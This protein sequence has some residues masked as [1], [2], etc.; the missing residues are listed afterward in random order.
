MKKFLTLLV[1]TAMLFAMATTAFAA[2]G[3]FISS[4]SNNLAPVL[5]DFTVDPADD[6]I[7]LIITPYI[8]RDE[9]GAEGKTDIEAAYDEIA[10]NADLTKIA[11]ALTDVAAALNLPTNV[12]AVS[13]LFDVSV[14]GAEP[15]KTYTFNI[16]LKAETLKNFVALLHYEDGEMVVVDDAKVDGDQLTFTVT[17]L[18]PFAVV[19]NT[20]SDSNP[21]QTGDAY[22][23]GACAAV[24]AASAVAF[25]VVYKKG[26]KSEEN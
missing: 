5:V 24:M 10:A 3:G 23:I 14:K 13:D 22:V 15:G 12:L 21:P 7:E 17:G 8:D 11:P 18:S 6:G 16:T 25:V 19:V 2:N 1:A 4:P 9:L 20:Y 26:R